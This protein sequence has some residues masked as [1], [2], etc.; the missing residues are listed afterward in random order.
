[1]NTTNFLVKL[2]FVKDYYYKW[3]PFHLDHLKYYDKAQA[4]KTFDMTGGTEFPYDS[5]ILFVNGLKQEEV[6]ELILN[7]PFYKK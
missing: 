5:G 7:D 1:M 2:K 3:I 6:H 4:K